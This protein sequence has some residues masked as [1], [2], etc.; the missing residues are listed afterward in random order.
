MIHF[1]LIFLRLLPYEI[2]LGAIEGIYTSITIVF[3]LW[4]ETTLRLY[5]LYIILHGAKR[6]H[7]DGASRRQICRLK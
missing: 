2:V 4:C 7:L 6:L 1:G 3:N 5:V